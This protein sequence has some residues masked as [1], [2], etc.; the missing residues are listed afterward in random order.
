MTAEFVQ[1]PP[2]L[3]TAI[4]EAG[5]AVAA[6]VCGFGVQAVVVHARPEDHDR[7]GYT[8]LKSYPRTFENVVMRLAGKAAEHE[9]LGMP[10]EV[11]SPAVKCVFAAAQHAGASQV[12]C[13]CMFAASARRTPRQRRLERTGRMVE[14][15]HRGD[16]HVSRAMVTRLL[17]FDTVIEATIDALREVAALI[18]REHEAEVRRIARALL[19]HDILDG[20]DLDRL[21]HGEKEADGGI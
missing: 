1:P 10:R 9:L 7:R 8:S 17:G 18:V 2:R 11:M 3:I 15:E 5:H 13:N 4:H 6:Q 20:E 14:R 21:L 16:E 12:L 19:T